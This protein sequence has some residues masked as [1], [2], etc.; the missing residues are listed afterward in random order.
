[1][2]RPRPLSALRTALT[3]EA[4][5]GLVLMA[6]AALALIVA[7]SPLAE[8]YAEALHLP[9]GP[10]SLLH[11]INDGLMA[12]FFLLVGLEIK[13]EALDGRLRTW[14]DRALPG[15]AALGGMV[16][17]ALVYVA[18]N[19][20]AGTLRGWA[21]PA[22]TDI[23]FAL[24]VLALLGAR[25]PVSL[26]I[27]L[28]AVAIVDDLGAVLIIAL[29]YTGG[30][31]PTMLGLAALTLG[32]LAALNRLGVARLA[33]YLVLGLALWFFVLRSG[34]HAT[35]AG[36]LLALTIPIRPSPGRPE[37]PTS[38]LHGLEHALTP[39]VTYLIVP[40][41]G[42]ANAGV[43]LVGVSAET[44][45]HP[46]TLGVALGLFLGKQAGIF[47]SVRLAVAAGLA[48]RPAGATWAQVYGVAILCGIGFTMSL[49]I[50][51]LAFADAA[52]E[53]ETKLGVLGGSLLSGIVGAALLALTAGRERASAAPKP[54]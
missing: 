49:F 42:F 10:L 38:P 41:F 32:A 4:A 40:V 1:M 22:A 31:D 16:V 54:A 19:A 6:A 20:G 26:K 23:A 27:F 43:R 2:N 48:S 14:P 30:L 15:L 7:N 29:F 35:V 51:G 34:V 12:V 36:V 39:W 33:P 17:P 3:S 44:I 45:L 9:L 21:I 11:W 37:D 13:R 28:S 47:A 52:H 50:G 25:A 8:A 5:G 46:V 18:L 53:T 24:G